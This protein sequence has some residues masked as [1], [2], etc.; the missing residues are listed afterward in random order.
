MTSLF[1]DFFEKSKVPKYNFTTDLKAIQDLLERGGKIHFF[2][3]LKLA[4]MEL[5][6]VIKFFVLH[7]CERSA[8]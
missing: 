4:K 1:G 2:L 3:F 5:M 6:V 8:S 7:F